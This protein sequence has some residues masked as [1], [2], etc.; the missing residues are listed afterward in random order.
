MLLTAAAATGPGDYFGELALLND[1]RRRAT[2][3]ALKPTTCLTLGRE[4]FKRLLG[5]LETLLKG[6]EEVYEKYNVDKLGE[7]GGGGK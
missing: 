6:R 3:R 1:D 4:T 5:P 7:G 2:V